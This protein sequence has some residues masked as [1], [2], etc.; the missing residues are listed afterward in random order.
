VK[1]RRSLTFSVALSMMASPVSLYAAVRPDLG[2]AIDFAVLGATTVTSTGLTVVNGDLGVSPGT[3]VTGFY[4]PGIVNGTI[5]SGFSSNAGPGQADAL[6]AYNFVAGQACNTDL[7]GSDLGGLTLTPG[8]Y[9]FDSSAELTGTLTLDF[10]GNSSAVF[11]F[12]IGSTL[13][14]ASNASVVT[15]NGFPS[16]NNVIWQ[17][18]SSATLG[19]GTAFFGDIL[20]SESITMTTDASNDG[21][22]YA[23]NGAVTLDTNVI[24]AC[25][26]SCGSNAECLDDGNVC[27]T[28]ICA[29]A[30]PV[31]D[32]D[33]C[34]FPNNTLTCDDALFC[35][36]GDVCA[37]GTCSGTA[38]DCADANSCTNDSCS[39]ATDVCLHTNNSIA[40]D[41]LQFCT[42]GDACSGGTCGGVPRDC[43]DSNVC[44]NDS[45]DEAGGICTHNDNTGLCDDGLFCTDGDSCS[46]GNCIPGAARDCGDANACTI[47]SCNENTDT[48]THANNPIACDDGQFCTVGDV[49]TGG[50]CAGVPR[51]CG[52]SNLCTNDACI[53]ATDTCAHVNNA[54]PCDD[55][56]FC[57]VGDACDSGTCLAGPA[58][59]CTDANACTID[60]CVE[61]TDLCMHV[62]ATCGNGIVELAC[63]EQCD[64]PGGELCNNGT[65]DDGDGEIDCADSDCVD[66]IP[67]SCSDE[68]QLLVPCIPLL[69]DPAMV[70]LSEVDPRAVRSGDF[71]FHGRMVPTTDVNP[72]LETFTIMLSNAAGTIFRADLPAGELRAT[73]KSR[74][75]FKAPDLQGDGIQSVRVK[76][77]RDG[78]VYGYGVR[79]KVSADLS[80]ATVP[81]MTTQIYLGNDVA[82]V[83]A[84]WKLG[85]GRW[86]L[87]QSQY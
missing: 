62:S 47:D 28:Q 36:V 78:G 3:A 80:S 74:F 72:A 44:T 58:R 24:S 9:C 8:V 21:S 45:C 38:R 19:T 52:D 64:V 49:C 5:Y 79:V 18:G 55:G 6:D 77:R 10:Q 82:F 63:G 25:G 27:T 17:V 75:L 81:R 85:N 23:L 7:T 59:D 48:C 20:A 16:C 70:Y 50:A 14:T 56:E 57:T 65:D 37:G 26:P 42:T 67:P 29:P 1:L 68:C 12:Q 35:T 33:G 43:T 83:T 66:A 71:S 41:D 4:P 2:T 69:R 61:A 31:A 30:D 73:R 40:C 51:D 86:T 22:L 54:V 87:S 76:R 60:S 32:V 34:T 39:E 11:I 46:A 84:N 15:I 13:T 53:E